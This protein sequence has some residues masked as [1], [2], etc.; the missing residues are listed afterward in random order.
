MAV[1]PSQLH[2]L[3]F[4]EGL[5]LLDSME[6]GLLAIDLNSPEKSIVDQVFRAAH[7][8]KGASGT[9]GFQEIAG[10]THELETLL[11]ELRAQN[12]NWTKSHID[13]LLK[14]VDV[15][16]AMFDFA[17]A[18][19]SDLTILSEQKNAVLS[20]LGLTSNDPISSDGVEKGEVQDDVHNAGQAE[21]KESA[22]TVSLDNP[23]NR[24]EQTSSEVLA[25]PKQGE[26]VFRFVPK[27]EFFLTGNDPL[28]IFRELNGYASTRT[29]IISLDSLPAFDELDHTQSYLSWMVYISDTISDA[30]IDEAFDWVKPYCELEEIDVS[31]DEHSEAQSSDNAEAKAPISISDSDPLKVDEKIVESSSKP[32]Q[33]EPMRPSSSKQEMPSVRVG[34]NKIDS[35]MDMVGEMV[36][37]QSV[38]DD[39]GR[40]LT[41]EE[42]PKLYQ[43]IEQIQHHTRDLREA[44]L[45]IRMLPVQI[46]FSRFPR[47]VHDLSSSLGKDVNLV[48]EGQETE[49][50]KTVI[51]KITDPLMHLVR[52]A[53]DHGVEPSEDRIQKGKPAR[54]TL[55]LN[56]F[57]QGS[58]VVIEISDDGAGLNREIILEKARSKGLVPENAELS[59]KDIDQLIFEPGFSTAKEV[60]DV[61]GRGVGM[62]VVRQNIRDLNGSIDLISVPNQGCKISI[63]LP[64]T[65]AIVDG[66]LVRVGDFTFIIPMRSIIESMPFDSSQLKSLS[67]GAHMLTVRE[68]LVPLVDL[69]M[70]FAGKPKADLSGRGLVVLVEANDKILALQVDE[71]LS[72]QPVVIKRL[73]ENYIHLDGFAGAAVLGNGRIAYILE[74]T[75]ILKLSGAG[76]V[77]RSPQLDPEIA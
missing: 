15:L 38:I 6:N 68:H 32:R 57:Q 30:Q 47:V 5:E 4:E 62:D 34:T 42:L 52:N 67:N 56:A 12:L 54:A 39:I 8:I 28:R 18:G 76:N 37:A 55:T 58:S 3:F 17:M 59:P 60:T 24:A 65:L 31:D 10:F 40:E 23:N 9:F 16:R 51:E 70:H 75:D 2:A 25:T 22:T 71:L 64:L 11:S 13:G 7:S 20:E 46:V 35:L 77:Y 48:I 44:V 33:P 29:Q 21:A 66:Q 41:V 53:L 19:E 74:V 27:P 43:G 72:Q 69:G 49:L 73:D 14:S 36:I 63:R 1:D 61:S 45:K 50:D 26:R